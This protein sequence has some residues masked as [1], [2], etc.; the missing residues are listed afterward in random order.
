MP[1]PDPPTELE[2][3]IDLYDEVR[4]AD[5]DEPFPSLDEGA[6]PNFPIPDNG[7]ETPF[8]C[9]A[10]NE[11]PWA[12]AQLFSRGDCASRDDRGQTPLMHAALNG[13]LENVAM[14]LPKSDPEA[15]DLEQWTALHYALK[16]F[17]K[18]DEASAIV[19]LLMPLTTLGKTTD[20]GVTMLMAAAEG[21]SVKAVEDLLARD[22][23]ERA[24][25]EKEQENKGA[26]MVG[27]GLP[28][29]GDPELWVNA[30]CEGGVTALMI[31][32]QAG[33]P[34]CVK[35]LLCAP[36]IDIQAQDDEGLT[37][38]AHA[39]A[40]LVN[41]SPSAQKETVEM[42]LEACPQSAAWI[43]KRPREKG[44]T[45]LMAL[46][47]A[48][49]HTFEPDSDLIERLARLSD[50]R[51]VC[52]K[53]R[54]ALMHSV[55]LWPAPFQKHLL[56]LSDANIQDRQGKTALMAAI[57]SKVGGNPSAER[58][59]ELIGATNVNLQ[60][61]RGETA[62]FYAVRNPTIAVF[63]VFPQLLRKS[64]P[65]HVSKAGDTV[66][67]LLLKDLKNPEPLLY[68]AP[69][70]TDEEVGA[71][72]VAALSKTNHLLGERLSSLL[73]REELKISARPVAGGAS[74]ARNLSRRRL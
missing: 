36:G 28:S 29:S 33:S 69:L 6:D 12:L 26:L 2:L 65:R 13:C 63:A 62:L 54:T 8:M 71:Y 74:E 43:D 61:E 32:S 67:S 25:R 1:Y 23:Y 45:I 16:R 38:L 4:H 37:A 9:A 7:G 68:L 60:D 51:A 21:G 11:N 47:N 48:H 34:E 40:R 70:M 58:L 20:Q 30:R 14:L 59:S 42:L 5:A 18:N 3:A 35:A 57:E 10:R 15:Q 49:P 17:Q 56:P 53:G 31:A 41:S 24:Q 19:D 72:A 39:A 55:R 27:K 22:A 46:I 52:E 50:L 66:F 64:N 44:Q 73:V